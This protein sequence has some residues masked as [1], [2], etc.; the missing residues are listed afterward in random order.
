MTGNTQIVG[1]NECKK[2]LEIINSIVEKCKQ[3]DF[4]PLEQVMYIYDIVRNREY[5]M[6]HPDEDYTISRD[7]TSVLLGNSIVCLGYS[8]IFREILNNLGIQNKLVFLNNKNDTTG[9]CRNIVYIK[10]EKYNIDGVYYFDP[11][12]DS[13]RDASNSFLSSYKYFARTQTQMT[14]L[15]KNKYE[16]I[17]FGGFNESSVQK[18]EDFIREKGIKNI[19]DKART[20]VNS[21][22]N[23]IDGVSWV[24]PFDMS[25]IDLPECFKSH[26]DLEVKLDQLKEYCR[27]FNK[28]IELSTFIKL[29]YNVRKQQYY[30]DPASYPFNIEEI[31]D[32]IMNSKW[33][34]ENPEE[35]L[36]KLIFGEIDELST[37]EKADTYIE[38]E[39]LDKKIES[40]RLAR[41]LRNVLQKRNS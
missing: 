41:T 7:L 27:K 16:D 40:V 28:P 15:S 37:E 1:F 21:I 14:S 10:D 18:L 20:K 6:E 19:P 31:H 17:Y 33:E 35:R 30:Y 5:E 25:D 24:T 22:S 36:M 13:K 26:F 9:H 8:N 11:T 38:E 3:F 2:T 12:W 39:E 29:L 34:Y 4:S 32:T 23:L